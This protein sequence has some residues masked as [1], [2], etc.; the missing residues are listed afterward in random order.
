MGRW[1]QILGLGA[2]VAALGL[3]TAGAG[4]SLAQGQAQAQAASPPPAATAAPRA[5]G[6][7][8]PPGKAVYDQFCAAC[9]DKPTPGDRAAPVEA[10]RKM[11]GQTLMT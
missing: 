3:M 2:A 6:D 10:L 5:H 4:T 7:E 1:K 11:S 8:P 9:H